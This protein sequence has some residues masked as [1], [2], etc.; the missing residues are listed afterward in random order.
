[1]TSALLTDDLSLLTWLES[2][3][4]T[5][6][7]CWLDGDWPSG[8]SAHDRAQTWELCMDHGRRAARLLR[9]LRGEDSIHATACWAGDDSVRTCAICGVALDTGGLTDYG[10]RDILEPDE[11]DQF[12]PDIAELAA[13]ASALLYDD[14]RWPKLLALIAEARKELAS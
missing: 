3:D 14:P 8:D 12:V 1:M 10:V 4:P 5:V 7:G 13:C 9:R 2:V 11:G 6:T